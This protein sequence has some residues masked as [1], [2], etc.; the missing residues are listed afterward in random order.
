MTVD[1]I[2]WKVFS[3]ALPPIR[4]SAESS[5]Q[6]L[7]TAVSTIVCAPRPYGARCARL[8]T[9]SDPRSRHRKGQQADAVDVDARD[10]RVQ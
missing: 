7:R 3:Q 5:C 2:W 8:M 1:M 9:A 10:R 4:T 6:A